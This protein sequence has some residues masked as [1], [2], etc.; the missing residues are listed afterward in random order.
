M[1]R[2]KWTGR[3]ILLLL[4]MTLAALS[5]E[6]SGFLQFAG[7]AWVVVLSLSLVLNWDYAAKD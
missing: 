6:S 4:I 7:Y 2:S 5:L 1:L 3:V